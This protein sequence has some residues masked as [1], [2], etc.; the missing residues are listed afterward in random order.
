[1]LK[2]AHEFG[3][4]D[5]DWQNCP[6][7][8]LTELSDNLRSRSKP[9]AA[10]YGATV[11]AVAAML[12]AGLLLGP[13]S[14]AP[15]PAGCQRVAPMLAAYHQNE[16]TAEERA[17]V[18]SHLKV[19]PHCRQAYEQLREN[20]PSNAAGNYAIRRDLVAKRF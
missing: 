12:A 10:M 16:L 18:E 17:E 11:S 14:E 5:F 20:Q 4:S 6:A 15:M 19:C 7:G 13:A 1:M 2:Q 9:R 8:T 3:D